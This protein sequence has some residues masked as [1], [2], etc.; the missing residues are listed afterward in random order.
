VT[1]SEEEAI[2]IHRKYGSNSVI[3]EHCRTVEKVALALAE[4]FA[5]RGHRVDLNAVAA[6]ALLHDIGR[7]RVQTVRHGVEGAEMVEKEG[8]DRKVVEIVRRHVGAGIAPEE[9]RQ[10][11]LPDYDFIPGTLEERIVCF[12]DKMVDR[13]RVR[14]FEEEVRRFA[15][16][17]HDVGR[18]LALKKGLQDEL[19]EDP[20]KVVFEKLKDPE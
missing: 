6:G 2:A 15:I 11:G 14:P 8:V 20:E 1:P 18:L 19:G 7:S 13:N 16:K 10:L 12:A 17:S 5:R 9:A 4:E 3:V